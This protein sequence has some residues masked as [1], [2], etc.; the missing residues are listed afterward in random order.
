MIVFGDMVA[1]MFSNKKLD[2]IVTE[3]FIRFKISNF[4]LVF[5]T[6]PYFA[7]PKIIRL[8][9]SHNFVM[10][11][12]N[13]QGLQQIAFNYSSDCKRMFFLSD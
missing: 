9:S 2:L 6:Q 13:K 5:I 12:P 10:K 8:N 1:D 4:S 7:A 3:L 11:I